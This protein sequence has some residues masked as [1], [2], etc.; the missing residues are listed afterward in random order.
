MR[1]KHP[2]LEALIEEIMP[3]TGDLLH[4]HVTIVEDD[5]LK[6]FNMFSEESLV[7]KYRKATDHVRS[8]SPPKE[9]GKTKVS[10]HLKEYLDM[11]ESLLGAD[12]SLLGEQAASNN[13]VVHGDHTETGM[14][15]FASDPHLANMIPS[16]W[17]LY[18]LEFTDGSGHRISG[19]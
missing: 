11:K 5:D 9:E 7:E 14:P 13:F 19:G 8:A 16:A 18:S 1:Q 12:R 10:S 3:F 2:D 15:L 6:Q 4:D 17:L